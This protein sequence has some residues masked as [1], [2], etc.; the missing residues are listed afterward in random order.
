MNRLRIPVWLGV[1]GAVAVCLQAPLASADAISLAF[2]EEAFAAPGAEVLVPLRTE[3]ARGMGALQFEIR[4]DPGIV[5]A[6][7]VA[8]GTGMPPMLIEYHVVSPGCL[9]VALA[10]NEAMD[11]D[12]ELDLRFRALSPGHTDLAVQDAQAWELDAG[13]DLLVGVR[14]GRLVVR[15][16]VASGTVILLL[17]LGAVVVVG[18]ALA[19]ARG[20]RKGPTAQSG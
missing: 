14:P 2:P 11:G 16:G 10:G 17:V 20:R 5:E 19:V 12:A 3:G 8:A 6:A 18:I 1:I 13:H 7:G 4:F 15:A 9:R